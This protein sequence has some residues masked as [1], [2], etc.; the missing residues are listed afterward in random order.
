VGNF[1]FK[2]TPTKKS[3]NGESLDLIVSVT[4]KEIVQFAKTC[5]SNALKCMIPF[6]T[7]V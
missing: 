2:V 3:K 5:S 6:A 4:G 7:S 1:D